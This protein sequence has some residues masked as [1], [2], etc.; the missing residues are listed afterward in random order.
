[1]SDLIDAKHE[2][3]LAYSSQ[4]G[5]DALALLS[6]LRTAALIERS[7]ADLLAPYGL[8]E[9]KLALLLALEA[10]GTATPAR[11]A[12]VL[13]VT[14]AAV[15]GLL[16]ALERDGL[17][18]RT[19]RD[20]DRRSVAVQLTAEGRA[21]LRR[22]APAYDAWLGELTAGIASTHARNATKIL[23]RIQQNLETIE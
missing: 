3:L 13:D 9:N 23:Q 20:A 12:D 11:L 17:L 22:V 6:V 16:D 5:H 18:Q 10:H 21:A 7:C 2:L 15:T 4:R 14:R 1:M 19:T 8:T